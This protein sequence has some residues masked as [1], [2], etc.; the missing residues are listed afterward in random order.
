MLQNI[1]TKELL[2]TG[3]PGD[4]GSADSIYAGG[5]K[6][7]SNTDQIYNTFADTRVFGSNKQ[8][9]HANGFAQDVTINFNANPGGYYNVDTRSLNTPVICTLP[10]IAEYASLVAYDPSKATPGTKIKFL[11]AFKMWGFQL[12]KV[13]ATPGQLINNKTEIAFHESGL[14]VE[15]VASSYIENSITKYEWIVNSRTLSDVS[16]KPLNQNLFVPANNPNLEFI[17]ADNRSF[18]SVKFMMYVEELNGA[19]GETLRNQTCEV[20]LLSLPDHKVKTQETLMNYVQYATVV[21]DTKDS[22][23]D[24]LFSYDFHVRNVTLANLDVKPT[25]YIDITNECANDINIIVN[26][27]DVT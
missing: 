27:I 18:N 26:A 9:L 10:E 25:V 3:T 14:E 2:N 22:D 4:G 19:N 23:F 7:V 1:K 21:Y 13:V 15:L 6:I 5:N 24:D 20:L 17:I 16:N 8:F 12:F 11:D